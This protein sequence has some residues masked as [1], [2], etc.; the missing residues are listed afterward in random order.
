M[1]RV[2]YHFKYRKFLIPQDDR[3]DCGVACIRTILKWY[4]VSSDAET[5]RLASGTNRDGT[6]IQGLQDAFEEFGFDSEGYEADE[7]SQ[8]TNLHLPIILHIEC[9]NWLNHFVVLIE[10]IGNKFII[11]DPAQ[12]IVVYSRDQIEN[13]W[14]SKILLTVSKRKHYDFITDSEST[15]QSFFTWLTGHLQKDVSLLSLVI[16]FGIVSTLSAVAVSIF[17][18][19]IIDH[20]IPQKSESK[21]IAALC[22]LG[23][24]FIIRSLA[25]YFKSHILI[26]H[27]IQFNL[28]I[29]STF[30]SKLLELP[31]RF[32]ESRRT[33]DF[34]AR[35][36]DAARI[37]AVIS[38]LFSQMFIDFLLIAISL[39]VILIY[40]LTVF[41]MNILGIIIAYVVIYMY[42]SRIS[43]LQKN[44]MNSYA[45]SESHFIDTLTGIF[46]IKNHGKEKEFAQSNLSTYKL[47]QESIFNLGKLT[48]SYTL[49]TEII[50]SVLLLTILWFLVFSV[51]SKTLTIGEFV[52][53]TGLVS[54]SIPAIIRLAVAN[55][56][57]QE[58]RISFERMYEY[59]QLKPEVH[60]DS[61]FDLLGNDLI[62]FGGRDI[63]FQYPGS[64]IILSNVEFKVNIGSITGL[65]GPSGCGK[66]TLLKLFHGYYAK[67]EGVIFLNDVPME[68]Y[69]KRYWRSQIAYLSQENKIFNGS[70]A[71]NIALEERQ[72]IYTSVLQFIRNLGLEEVFQK[73][74]L[75]V[76]TLLGEEGVNLSGGQKQLIGLIRVLYHQPKVLLLDEPFTGMDVELREIV[77]GIIKLNS[78]Q[79]ITILTSHNASDLYY[80]DRILTIRNGG[81]TE[82]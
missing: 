42:S 51:F 31:Y 50:F 35:L 14:T 59:S 63:S 61:K 11:A 8:L 65:T 27:N 38:V 68:S 2:F 73:F 4:N 82:L 18:Q 21:L 53:V 13:R 47:F 71:Y 1:Y 39:M 25:N 80:C 75:S 56:N 45:S 77:H 37:Q 10:V 5:V 33:G 78:T 79:C 30:F 76:I 34:V 15:K 20:I 46:T 48:S 70:L 44:V 69:N 19:R 36:N 22:L 60:Y 55:V 32:F 66:S 9:D 12:G 28:R 64:E 29:V 58:A 3:F 74:N 16:F 52:A 67:Y 72:L 24:V 23:C 43:R 81:V 6:T 57:I 26:A 62:N 49:M 17:S 41:M 7:L 40:S 54:T